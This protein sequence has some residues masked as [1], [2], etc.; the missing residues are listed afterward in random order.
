MGRIRRNKERKRLKPYR[1][2]ANPNTLIQ[3]SKSRNQPFVCPK[4][5][6]DM[7]TKEHMHKL[8]LVNQKDIQ[9]QIVSAWREE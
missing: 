9:G 4:A 5:R 8:L 1:H 7:Y 2:L 3:V 6:N